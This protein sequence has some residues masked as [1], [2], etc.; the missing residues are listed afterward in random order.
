MSWIGLAAPIARPAA[1]DQAAP[2]RASLA[3]RRWSRFSAPPW[4]WPPER[5]EHLWAPS[6]C[7][8]RAPCVG[9]A[10]CLYSFYLWHWP[11]LILAAAYAGHRLGLFESLVVVSAALAAAVATYHAVENPIRRARLLHR[12]PRST[13]L[14]WPAA[15][16]AV[17]ASSVWTTAQIQHAQEAAADA[18]RNVDLS[19]VPASERVPRTASLAHNGVA[20]ALDRATLDSPLPFPLSQ[21]LTTLADDRWDGAHKCAALPEDTSSAICPVG[22]PTATRSVVL[23]GD[24]HANMWLPALDRIGQR[25]GFRVVPIIK[26]GCSPVDIPL[27]D[28]DV[29]GFNGQCEEWRDWALDQVRALH[30][31]GGR[32]RFGRRRPSTHSWPRTTR[33]CSTRRQRWTHGRTE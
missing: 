4:R 25:A 5:P 28:R 24:S 29:G 12:R 10:T 18:Y 32:R 33:P 9:S 2:D 26:F 19:Q 17:L 21:D 13:L 6:V 30:P 7:C 27:Y 8:A 14:L 23:L 20:D 3:G 31:G 11:M 1:S 15:L 16:G 22:D